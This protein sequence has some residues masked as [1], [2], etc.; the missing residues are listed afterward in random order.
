VGFDIMI[1]KFALTNDS[2][3]TIVNPTRGV[4]WSQTL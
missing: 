3:L 1:F 4:W 2:K